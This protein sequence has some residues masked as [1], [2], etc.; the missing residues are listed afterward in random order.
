[1]LISSQKCNENFT[2]DQC[3]FLRAQ[4]FASPLMIITI[5]FSVV[6]G[7]RT[8]CLMARA[9]KNN[10]LGLRDNCRPMISFICMVTVWPFWFLTTRLMRHSDDIELNITTLCFYLGCAL[11][12]GFVYFHITCYARKLQREKNKP[13]EKPE[14]DESMQRKLQ[15]FD[16]INRASD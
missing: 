15:E 5:I 1:M 9:M 6:F 10:R 11:F 3:R 13:E 12:K 14:L 16:F 8:I 7:I 4:F 2:K